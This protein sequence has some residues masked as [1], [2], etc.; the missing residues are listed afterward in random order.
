ML[1]TQTIPSYYVY[2]LDAI[3]SDVI[4]QGDGVRVVERK[5]GRTL[6]EVKQGS[7][8]RKQAGVQPVCP[9]LVRR[10]L[11]PADLKKGGGFDGPQPP[12]D[13]TLRPRTRL[14]GRS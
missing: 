2:G 13:R 5:S 12:V 4:V 14:T 11:A 7:E 1:M 3:A 6:C 9:T 8:T 10:E